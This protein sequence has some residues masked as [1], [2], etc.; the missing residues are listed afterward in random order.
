MRDPERI[1]VILDLLNQIWEKNPDLRFHQLLYILQSGFSQQHNNIG[2]V[3]SAGEDGF[4]R[5]GYDL[6]NVEDDT[7]M[8]Y[9][10]QIVKNGL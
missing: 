5:V 2:K 7:F 6:F 1:T 9:L 3:E 8:E 4:A 10:Q